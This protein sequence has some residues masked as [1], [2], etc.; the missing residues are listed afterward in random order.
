MFAA[1]VVAATRASLADVAKLVESAG[2]SPPSSDLELEAARILQ[3]VRD[4]A[5][6]LAHLYDV[7][8]AGGVAHPPSREKVAA[9]ATG[10]GLPSKGWRR[11]DYLAALKQVE[12]AVVL[13]AAAVEAGAT[14]LPSVAG[15]LASD[16]VD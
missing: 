15:I 9:A 5:S 2:T 14:A 16:V 10:L 4:A 8:I 1:R 6:P 13:I 3:D 11:R 7:R 12:N